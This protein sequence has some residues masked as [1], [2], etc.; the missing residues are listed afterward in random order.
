MCV[1]CAVRR[2]AASKKVFFLDIHSFG[3]EAVPLS[4]FALEALEAPSFEEEKCKEVGSAM[5]LTS[6]LLTNNSLIQYV[7]E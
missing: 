1:C 4:D 7:F 6:V 5:N 2:G 3:E